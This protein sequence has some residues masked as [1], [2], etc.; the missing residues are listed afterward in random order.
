[1]AF[2]DLEE[3]YSE[4]RIIIKEKGLQDTPENM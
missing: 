2:E 3:I 4:I 1:M